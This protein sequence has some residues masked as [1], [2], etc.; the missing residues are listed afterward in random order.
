MWSG[1]GARGAP[2]QPATAA[3]WV[4]AYLA[5]AYLALV[6]YAIV[7]GHLYSLP[8]ELS[9]AERLLVDVLRLTLGLHVLRP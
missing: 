7:G 5:L 2:T 3:G 8:G 9:Q 6:V 1:S 4:W